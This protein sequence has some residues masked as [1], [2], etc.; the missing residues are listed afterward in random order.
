[1]LN[2]NCSIQEIIESQSKTR[3]SSQ[4]VEYGSKKQIL[5]IDALSENHKKF[6]KDLKGTFSFALHNSNKYLIVTLFSSKDKKYSYIIVDLD[7]M[8]CAEC[9]SI[10]NAKLEIM[11]LVNTETATADPES[12]I[13]DQEPK[14]EKY[15]E[16]YK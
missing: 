10:K 11:Q 2:F 16:S 8:N 3:K 13:S 9:N 1:M 12:D 7:T 14:K 15:K 6:I 5:E 4:F